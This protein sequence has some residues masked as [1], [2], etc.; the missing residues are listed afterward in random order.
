MK[1]MPT[2][3]LLKV[4]LST[5]QTIEFFDFETQ[6]IL[7][8]QLENFINGIQICQGRFSSFF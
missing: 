5:F 2:I 3:F 1:L 4:V 6:L 8:F 7:C